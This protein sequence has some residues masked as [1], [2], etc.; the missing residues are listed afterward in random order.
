MSDIDFQTEYTGREKPEFDKIL[1]T[2][3][4]EGQ[5]NENIVG[6]IVF[7]GLSDITAQQA[8][9]LEPVWNEL[10]TSYKHKVLVAFNE[11]SEADFDLSYKQV[12][13]LGL[14]DESSLVRAAAV[15]LLWDDESVDTLR[16][17]LNLVRTDDAPSVKARALVSLGKYILLG[18]YEEIPELIAYEAQQLAFELHTDTSQPLEVRRRALEALS[19]SS[20]A[21]KDKLIQNAYHSPEHLLRVSAVFAMGRTCDKKWE[22]ILLEELDGEDTEIVYEAVRACGE[23][24]LTSSVRQLGQLLL[25]DDREIQLMVIWSLGEIGGQQAVDILTFYEESVEDE[26]LLEATEDALGVASFNLSGAMFDFDVDDDY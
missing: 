24:G 16:L 7:Y 25:D 18:E 4:A 13:L 11:A 5:K 14:K 12:A 19:N 9:Q 22:D 17:L 26:D 23:I 1:A 2:L 15:D 10:P 8:K 20:H 3:S 21:Q 6:T